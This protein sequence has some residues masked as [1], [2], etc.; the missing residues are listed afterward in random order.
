MDVVAAGWRQRGGEVI[1]PRAA[2]GDELARVHTPEYLRRIAAT[3]GVAV[4][5]DPDTCTSPE[6]YDIALLAAG[7]A[8]DGVERV[9]SGAHRR[10][11]VLSRPPGHHAERDRAM[12]FCL[13]NNVAAA[14]A[15]A[16]MLG[17]ARIAIVDFDVHHGNGTQHIFEHDSDTLYISTHQ[18]PYYPGTGAAGEIGY[19]AAQG[20]TVNLPLEAGAIDDDYRIVFEQVIAPVLHQFAP[21]LLLVSAGYDAHIRDPL[22]GM[23]VTTDAFAAMAAMLRSIADEHCGGRLV[24]VTEGGYDLRAFRECLQTTVDVL[25]ADAAPAVEWPASQLPSSRGADAVRQARAAHHRF[26]QF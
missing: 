4:A 13:F 15:H 5:L 11:L 17:A 22:G 1:A 14:A 3:R 18:Y 23:R 12:G 26:W 9:L 21:D 20:R 7:A 2:T 16:R 8:L 19:G 24:A 10:A 25:A 6:S